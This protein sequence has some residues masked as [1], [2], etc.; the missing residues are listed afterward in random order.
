[1]YYVSVII[2]NQN[3]KKAWRCSDCE[4]STDFQSAKE[5]IEKYRSQNTVLA[6]WI[7]DEAAWT[8]DEAAQKI[9]YFKCYVDITGQVH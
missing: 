5:L 7:I 2:Q 1:M 3:D 6:A 9:R 4:G 8:I